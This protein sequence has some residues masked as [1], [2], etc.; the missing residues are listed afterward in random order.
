MEKNERYLWLGGDGNPVDDE[1]KR[2]EIPSGWGFLPAGDAGLTRKITARKQ[3]W[4]LQLK[5]GRR[6]MSKGIWAPQAII[7]QAQTEVAAQRSSPEYQRRLDGDRRRREAK[8]ALYEQE[9]MEAVRAY[10]NFAP[11][12]KGIEERMALAVT[13]HAVPVGS[14]TVARTTSLT[15]E[16][17]A[18]RAVIAWMRH[19][20][21]AY[22][23]MSIARVKGERRRVRRMLAVRSKELLS[24]Y[25]EGQNTDVHCPLQRALKKNSPTAPQ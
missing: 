9:F 10:L 21:T 6:V 16:E 22:E 24:A 12:Y 17:K 8:Q 25:R 20:T 14:G 13:R 19:Q 4:R 3:F 5:K 23:G 18:S 11:K 1:G 7:D 2:V 15:L